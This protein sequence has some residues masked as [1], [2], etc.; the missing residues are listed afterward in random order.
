M[1][2]LLPEIIDINKISTNTIDLNPSSSNNKESVNFGGGIELLMNDK[3]RDTKT[4]TSE[5]DIDDIDKL[6]NEL[7]DLTEITDIKQD[8]K[9]LPNSIP[10]NKKSDLFSTIDTETLA[11]KNITLENELSKDSSIDPEKETLKVNFGNI[12]KIS[13]E[14]QDKTWDGYNSFNNI[15]N[16]LPSEE[17]PTLSREE[18]LKEKFK[19]LRKLE[20]LEKKGINL[21]KKYSMDSSLDEM[22]GEYEMIMSEK[23]KS[24]S[25]KFQ[26]RMLMA[27]LTGIE[28]L[29]NKFDPFDIK[30][31]GW[32][33]QVHENI[34]D[35]DELFAELHEKYKSK[36]Q[37][38][39][40]IKLLL[41]VDLH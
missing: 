26:G 25:I 22:Q 34:D 16:K 20:A 15:P 4:P 11:S 29:N 32:S 1:T 28:F 9:F 14:S 23:E 3:K 10:N 33:E 35:Y 39:P 2:E 13:K 5:I 17:K 30:L 36:A 6:E 41:V 31:D 18:M 24:N 38:A 37:M 12:D 8:N 19:F 27:C 21:T 40:E 7:N